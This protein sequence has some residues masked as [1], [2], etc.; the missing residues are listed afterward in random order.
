A[1]MTKAQLDARATGTRPSLPLARYA[2][3][4]SNDLFGEVEVRLGAA[5]KLE[6]RL[7]DLPFAPLAHWHYDT[8]PIHWPPARLNKP[9]FSLLS[10]QLGGDGRAARIVISGPMLDADAVF[11]ADDR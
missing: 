3:R 4:F 5:G 1:G 8:L 2:G 7:A 11:A 6:W 9:P 10:F